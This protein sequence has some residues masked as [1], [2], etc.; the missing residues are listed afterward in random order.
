MNDFADTTSGVGGM[1]YQ[2]TRFQGLVDIAQTSNQ[3]QIDN[4]NRSI[5]SLERQTDK[6]RTSLTQRFAR[7]ESISA[8]LQSQQSALTSALSSLG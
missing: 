4:L 2:Y 6:I 8:Q 3:N 1:I 7:L 5:E